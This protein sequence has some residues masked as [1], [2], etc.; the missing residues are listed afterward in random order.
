M[1]RCQGLQEAKQEK[2]VGT[3][4]AGAPTKLSKGGKDIAERQP[5]AAKVA[6]CQAGLKHCVFAKTTELS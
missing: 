3:S 4:F 6:V 1:P 5:Q 2:K